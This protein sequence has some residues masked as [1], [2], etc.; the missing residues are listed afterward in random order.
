MSAGYY[1]FIPYQLNPLFA[2]AHPHQNLILIHAAYKQTTQ[3]KD[4]R[5]HTTATITNR[6]QALLL[7]FINKP[8]MFKTNDAVYQFHS[9]LRSATVRRRVFFVIVSKGADESL[10]TTQFR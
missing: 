4:K 9:L 8:A 5:L 7:L 3:T 2:E 6:K 10:A 1:A